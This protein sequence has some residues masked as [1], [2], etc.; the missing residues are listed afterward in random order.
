[1]VFPQ[2]THLGMTNLVSS[3]LITYPKTNY[4]GVSEHNNP[5]LWPFFHRVHDDSRMEWSFPLKNL[6]K[7]QNSL[8]SS[9]VP[10][11]E[12]DHL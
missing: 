9:Q 11:F 10:G 12:H 3:Q 6:S 5:K 7:L 1:L 8:R 2:T 4:L